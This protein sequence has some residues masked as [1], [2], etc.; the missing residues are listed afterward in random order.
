MGDNSARE[1]TGV[2]RQLLADL[3]GYD[4]PGVGALRL[5][6]PGV[7][8]RVGCSCGCGTIELVTDG[9]DGELSDAESP[10][11]VS[12]EIHDADGTAVGGI[13]LLLARGRLDSLE[14]YAY[15]DETLAMPD[16][17]LVTW[18]RPGGIPADETGQP[19]PADESDQP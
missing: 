14:V 1:L 18:F 9:Y 11:P 7:L 16:P 8:A 6:A 17:G 2:E 19:S 10:V 13:M 15:L 4:F 12:G 5:Q 3:L